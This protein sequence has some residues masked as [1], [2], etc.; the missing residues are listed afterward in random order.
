M[1]SNPEK[2]VNAASSYWVTDAFCPNKKLVSLFVPNNMSVAC[3]TVAQLDGRFLFAWKNTS[4]P[5]TE[6]Q[7]LEASAFMFWAT[8][9]GIFEPLIRAVQLK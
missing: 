5:G 8:V 6:K 9:I 1:N 3:C 7:Y 2:N 4:E